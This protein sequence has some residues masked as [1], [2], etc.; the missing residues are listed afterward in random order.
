M[1]ILTRFAEGLAKVLPGGVRK[2][3]TVDMTPEQVFGRMLVRLSRLSSGSRAIRDKLNQLYENR[4]WV[5]VC[6]TLIANKVADTPWWIERKVGDTWEQVQDHPATWVLDRPYSP[7]GTGYSL[8]HLLAQSLNLCGEF[9]VNILTA[10]NAGRALVGLTPMDSSRVQAL[11]DGRGGITGWQMPDGSMVQPDAI[12]FGCYPRLDDFYRGMSP[13]EAIASAVDLNNEVPNY[14]AKLL[15]NDARPSILLSPENELDDFAHDRVKAWGDQ[16]T[17][18]LGGIRILPFGVKAVTHGLAPKDLDFNNGRVALRSEILS[19]YHTPE[20]LVTGKD[21]NRSTMEQTIAYWLSTAI[22]PML[23]LVETALTRQVVWR[24]WGQGFRLRFLREAIEFAEDK[25]KREEMELKYNATTVNEYRRNRGIK[26]PLPWGDEMPSPKTSQPALDGGAPGGGESSKELA[27]GIMVLGPETIAVYKELPAPK[28]EAGRLMKWKAWENVVRSQEA[29]LAGALGRYNDRMLRDVLEN[30]R[31]AYKLGGKV[32]IS[33]YNE[34]V[35]TERMQKV[36]MPYIK[37]AVRSGYAHAGCQLRKP[38]KFDAGKSTVEQFINGMVDKNTRL[39]VST[40][41]Q[42]VADLLARAHLEPAKAELD[43][44]EELIEP[45]VA[46]IDDL[47]AE[48][49]DI[50]A[51]A[52][53]SRA[54]SAS[55][56]MTIG[57]VNWGMQDGYHDAGVQRK[58]WLT[59]QDDRVRDLHQLIDGEKVAM[60]SKFSNGLQYPGDPSGAPEEIINC[61]CTLLPVEGE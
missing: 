24:F 61:R 45:V 36:A 52:G 33:I 34:K 6:N 15:K 35:A 13:I 22:A 43:V 26:E 11:K 32:D 42:K 53:G 12:C 25:M 39:V 19:A 16:Q 55:T 4:S 58:E 18:K 5:F 27:K 2:Y 40:T 21:A 28:E 8:K 23:G 47:L 48:L 49:E 31:N 29:H 54:I 51:E 10:N 17:G 50:F 14:N 37:E 38:L 7:Y 56:T 41:K 30:A 46:S 44:A 3:Y 59:Q 57:S 20:I 60:S 9:Q 1:S